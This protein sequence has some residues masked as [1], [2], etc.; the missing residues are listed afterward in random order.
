MNLYC[1][2]LGGTRKRKP[3][4]QFV[5]SR[6]YVPYGCEYD[7]AV[8][9]DVF[10]D[11]ESNAKK[12]ALQF[13]MP[14]EMSSMITIELHTTVRNRVLRECISRAMYYHRLYVKAKKVGCTMAADEYLADYKNL[15]QSTR[16]YYEAER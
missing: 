9:V 4:S 6:W 16:E 12:Y 8:S 2:E 14:P 7:K 10:F 11:D 3:T 15:M 13:E 5:V 1:E